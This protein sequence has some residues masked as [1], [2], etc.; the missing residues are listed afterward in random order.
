MESLLQTPYSARFIITEVKISV[1]AYNTKEYEDFTSYPNL[2]YTYS[3][4][5][6]NLLDYI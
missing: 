3:H 1:D 2:H 5:L 4:R 6:K